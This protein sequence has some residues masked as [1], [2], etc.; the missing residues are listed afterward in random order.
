[1]VTDPAMNT[2]EGIFEM[3]IEIMLYVGENVKS[4]KLI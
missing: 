2:F 4:F 1:M 3:I